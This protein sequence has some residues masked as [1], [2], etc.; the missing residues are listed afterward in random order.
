MP[1][2][3]LQ[4]RKS[5]RVGFLVALAASV[6]FAGCGADEPLGTVAETQDGA[7]DEDSANGDAAPIDGG[8]NARPDA[9]QASDASDDGN[10]VDPLGKVVQLGAG[11]DH[12]CARFASGKVKCW[13]GNQ[14]GQLGLGDTQP[15]GD[16][17]GEMG[18]ALP[19]VDLGPGRTA[20]AITVA[21][22]HT[23]ARLDNGAVKC[24]GD[25]FFGALGI[26]DEA[27]RGDQPGEMGAALPA[28]D[29]GTGRTAL[30]VS[31]GNSSSCARL[32]D[33]EVKCW[34]LGFIGELGLGDTQTRGD[35]P[36]EMGSVLPALDF[37]PS[38]TAL[39]LS[40]TELS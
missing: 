5:R 6:A 28:V 36:G 15:R 27:A 2:R 34:G 21:L 1:N 35:S 24:W 22:R 12:T 40:G 32:D 39:G 26:G 19:S 18:A 8:Q 14:H 11:K 20:T 33:G 9:S 10:V 29:F 38:R 31:A 30:E 3:S 16:G 23:C 37:G 13:G 25:H 17:P 4:R 7:A